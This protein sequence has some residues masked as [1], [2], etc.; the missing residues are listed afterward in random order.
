MKFLL[1]SL[2]EKL[3][4]SSSTF[5]ISNIDS[6]RFL[7]YFTFFWHKMNIVLKL[8]Q[9]HKKPPHLIWVKK[10]IVLSKCEELSANRIINYG[11]TLPIFFSKIKNQRG[12]FF[13][14]IQLFEKEI[15]FEIIHQDLPFLNIFDFK[16]LRK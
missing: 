14:F 1:R 15:K 3:E 8:H 10:L 5:H 13:I 6:N 11:L 4:V 12:P 16:N 2:A 7:A 9:P